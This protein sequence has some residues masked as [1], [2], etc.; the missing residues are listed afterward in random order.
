MR[1]LCFVVFSL[2]LITGCHPGTSGRDVPVAGKGILDLRG[3]DPGKD[4]PV[5]LNGEWEFY[6]N[7]LYGPGDFEKLTAV[8]QAPA[9]M[10]FPGLW[11]NLAHPPFG[12]AT[13]RLKV[14]LNNPEQKLALKF[15]DIYAAYRVFVN[16]R[17]IGGSGKVSATKAGSKDQVIPKMLLLP[18]SLGDREVEIILQVSNHSMYFSGSPQAIRLGSRDD[19][20]H[21]QNIRLAID[22]FLIG[23]ILVMAFYHLGLFSLRNSDK[24]SLYFALL[25][26]GT[27]FYALL[28]GES[29]LFSMFPDIDVTGLYRILIPAMISTLMFA[30]MFMREIFPLEF[31]SLPVRAT[32]FFTAIAVGC[33]VFTPPAVFIRLH[34]PIQVISVLLLIYIFYALLRAVSR[35]RTGAVVMLIGY[36]IWF[37]TAINDLLYYHL[38]IES[39][40]LVS[41]GL[42]AFIFSQAF[43]LSTRFNEAFDLVAEISGQLEKS[44]RELSRLDRIK[45]EFLSNTSH[46][47][48]TPLNGIIGLAQSLLDGLTGKPSETAVKNLSLIVYSGKRL[49]NLVNDIL[50][51]SMLKNNE[52][53]LHR[54]GV[55]IRQ[56]VD[57]IFTVLSPIV[58]QKGIKLVADIPENLPLADADENRLEQI[59]FNLIGNSIRFTD[60]GSITVRA[61]LQSETILIS[62]IDTGTGIPVDRQSTIFNAFEQGGNWS[63]KRHAGTGLGLSITKN[64]VEL[65]GGQISVSSQPGEGSKFD[66]NLPVYSGKS[67]SLVSPVKNETG[68]VDI[69]SYFHRHAPDPT[70]NLER[71][72]PPIQDSTPSSVSV[73]P[74]LAGVSVLT[75][76]DD[77]INLIVI[78]NILKIAGAKATTARSGAACLEIL[79]SE[80]PDIVLLDIMM[81]ELN[82]YRTAEKIRQTWSADELPIIFLTARN[83]PGDLKNSFISGGNDYITKPVS[84]DELIARIKIHKTLAWSRKDLQRAELKFR[85]IFDRAIEGIFQADMDGRVTSANPSMATIFGYESASQLLAS[86]I[87]LQDL[88]DN[89]ENRKQ[90]SDLMSGK[91][92]SAGF[93]CWY[94]KKTDYQFWGSTF[95]RVIKNDL[96]KSDYIEGMVLDI[97]DRRK[98][99]IAE[100]EMEVAIKANQSK[101]DFL[102]MVT[103]EFRTPL[104]SILGYSQL[105]LGRLGK[106][107]ESQLADYFSTINDSGHR[108]LKM[109]NDLL[110]LFKYEEDG[111]EYMVQSESMFLI[112]RFVLKEIKPLIDQKKIELDFEQPTFTDKVEMD[113]TKI[114]QVILNLLSNA[115][116]FTDDGG[117]IS[118]QI[119][120]ANSSGLQV[121]VK[122]NGMGI[123]E[124][125]QESIFGK[126]NQS[127]NSLKVK[128]GTG[129]GLAISREIIK[130]HKGRI[131]AENN[132]DG[133]ASF[134]FVIPWQQ[135]EEG[136]EAAH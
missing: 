124:N 134:K 62:V 98:R 109:V 55:D 16:G 78:E 112:I 17:D 41:F 88:L 1:I 42:F 79:E 130:G 83:R 70:L 19:I 95:M 4:A 21:L 49:N 2:F 57:I 120:D 81:P 125:E 89:E 67:P 63:D 56:Q 102:A 104:S 123:P 37:T 119:K 50:D 74:E 82:G 105:G 22:L 80:Q 3:W 69:S 75:V 47:L 93:D 38:L 54:T 45:D 129:L 107:S 84:R 13:F 44:N 97:T 53:T 30:S 127:A 12:F 94:P 121:T 26:F 122:D 92:M 32:Q 101:S 27:I 113:E 58:E 11:T 40:N 35:K 90:L 135:A 111:M 29:F 20:Q 28:T 61:V 46:E 76:D 136:K 115:I 91:V 23:A 73:D 9:Y 52:V 31:S 96:H 43:L 103:H 5:R 100:R 15:Q 110:D 39:L 118:I 34:I 85:Q 99:E 6:W 8:S 7:K 131:W 60:K 68:D 126:F 25:C 77:N 18:D 87:K 106:L 36:C 65:H 10:I 114:S 14:L 86:G 108:L 71:Q 59:L 66:F 116:K 72:P 24:S 128:G 48:K 117:R 51:F 132:T 33:V 64:L 133:G